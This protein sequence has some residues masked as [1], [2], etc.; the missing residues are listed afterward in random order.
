MAA[1]LP[2]K[3]C[4]NLPLPGFCVTGC[5]CSTVMAALISQANIDTWDWLWFSLWCT[6]SRTINIT[7]NFYNYKDKNDNRHNRAF[8][9]GK[10]H[11]TSAGVE[12]VFTPNPIGAASKSD[13]V[14]QRSHHLHHRTRCVHIE[15]CSSL[16]WCAMK[17][18]EVLCKSSI[19][20]SRHSSYEYMKCITPAILF[21][22]IAHSFTWYNINII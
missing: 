5:L 3:N 4:G 2:L 22:I 14:V 10:R 21:S 17:F 12:C 16:C 18:V 7:P 11:F 8:W 20:L 9:L 13:R 15:L 6:I 1:I 19:T